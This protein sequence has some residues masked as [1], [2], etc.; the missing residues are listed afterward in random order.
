MHVLKTREGVLLFQ[1][2]HFRAQSWAWLRR[3]AGPVQRGRPVRA[4]LC[5]LIY[6]S[7][8][9]LG[10]ALCALALGPTCSPAHLDC[11][12]VVTGGMASFT[13]STSAWS[14]GLILWTMGTPGGLKLNAPLDEM[15]GSRF[16]YISQLWEDH[17][18]R[19]LT[20]P[21]LSNLVLAIATGC[22][23]GVSL[24]LAAL[25]DLLSLLNFS[26]LCF[27]VIMRR[28]LLLQLSGIRSVFH[29]EDW[30]E[31]EGGCLGTFPA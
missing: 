5:V 9:L 30:G 19:N 22:C 26:H 14:R 1:Q 27:H 24:G 2:V 8:L 31:G 10:L 29:L 17:V 4:G 12:G 18:Y 3:A 15:L 13:A 7:D 11:V 25:H 28:V 21:G 6:A 16:L 23:G 20:A